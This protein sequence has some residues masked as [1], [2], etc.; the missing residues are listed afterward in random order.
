[1]LK[2]YYHFS[3][4]SK[5]GVKR[6]QTS[7]NRRVRANPAH[8]RQQRPEAACNSAAFRP[9]QAHKLRL[10]LCAYVQGR[11]AE[12]IMITGTRQCI[13]DRCESDAGAPER[14]VQFRSC[15]YNCKLHFRAAGLPPPRHPK[16]SGCRSKACMH[17][18]R[19][20]RGE[21]AF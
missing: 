18:L 12:N 16:H 5:T 11:I 9:Q 19:E 3:I 15:S 1:V 10:R 21:K 17:G 13:R 7:I 2:V 4:T 6:R 14:K 8:R 20:P